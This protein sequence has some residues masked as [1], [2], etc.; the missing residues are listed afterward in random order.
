MKIYPVML[1]LNP[2]AF[3]GSEFINQRTESQFKGQPEISRHSQ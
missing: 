1:I 3:M 2:W